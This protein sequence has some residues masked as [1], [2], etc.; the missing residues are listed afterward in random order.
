MDTLKNQTLTPTTGDE[1]KIT[2][3]SPVRSPTIREDCDGTRLAP[4]KMGQS[5]CRDCPKLPFSNRLLV[6]QRRAKTH[7][8][9]G[10]GCLDQAITGDKWLPLIAVANSERGSY[11]RFVKAVIGQ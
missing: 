4:A 10:F 2:S 11:G 6:A 9:R 3:V 8:G 5:V 1:L 7:R